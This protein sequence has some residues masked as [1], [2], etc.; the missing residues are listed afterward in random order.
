M[1]GCTGLCPTPRTA[2]G[3]EGLGRGC[4]RLWCPGNVKPRA[5]PQ[6]PVDAAMVEHA[7]DRE[8]QRA[9]S[10]PSPPPASQF[11]G[12]RARQPPTALRRQT[13]EHQ[14]RDA[15]FPLAMD[16]APPGDQRPLQRL[17]SCLGAAVRQPVD[18]AVLKGG[19]ERGG[20]RHA[21]GNERSR[22]R[23]LY[24]GQDMGKTQ[25]HRKSIE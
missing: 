3:S 14:P 10:S 23:S 7:P 1:R 22:G 11:H 13:A 25:N 8:P 5:P 16:P 17:S 20:V 24:H 12:L 4:P 9:S 21:N 19:G 2:R 15:P 6:I 18:R